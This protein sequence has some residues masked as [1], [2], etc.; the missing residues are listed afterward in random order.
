MLML[1]VYSVG[2]ALIS[3]ADSRSLC[4]IIR[5]RGKIDF[6]LVSDSAR[7]VEMLVSVLIGNDLI[8]V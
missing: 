1:E 6:I 2:E 3:G 7:V 4:R 5:G 8:F